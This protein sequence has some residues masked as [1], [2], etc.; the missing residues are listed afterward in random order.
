MRLSKLISDRLSPKSLMRRWAIARTGRTVQAG[1]FRGMH[2]IDQAFGSAYLPKVLGT[3]ERELYPALEQVFADDYD[4]LIDIGVAEGYFAVGMASRTTARVVG[5]E[6]D[7]SASA[8]AVELAELNQVGD[9]LEMR[10]ECTPAELDELCASAARPFLLCDVDGYET[11]LLDPKQV[12]SLARCAILVELHEFARPG[13]TAEFLRR[14]EPTHEIE[15]LW[16]SPRTAADFPYEGFWTR[17][18]PSRYRRH[19][20]DELRPFEQAWMWMTPRV[21]QAAAA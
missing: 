7:A 6:C 3:Y 19:M 11:T 21:A 5:F 9:R 18:L 2:Y 1:P 15:V 20:V 16:Q 4:T 10:G 17:V 8:M 12:A 14:F 13:V